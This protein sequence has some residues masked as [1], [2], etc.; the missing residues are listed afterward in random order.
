MKRT[1]HLVGAVSLAC[2]AALAAAP[3]RAQE[4]SAAQKDVWKSVE[5]YWALDA[6]G[7]VEGF[8][9]YFDPSYVGWSYDSPMPGDTS[10]VKKFVTQE[11]QMSKTLVYDIT[12]VAIQVHGD[13]AFAD[14]YYTELVKNA[15]GKTEE[16]KGRWT[17]ILKK[18]GDRWMLIGDH[19]GRIR[20]A[21]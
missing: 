8:M 15:E 1:L 9:A 10:T 2:L 19:G 5:N 7:D 13:F 6:K 11:Y 18:E 12:P 20:K 17:D 3:A 16:V 21:D 14:Y 4:W